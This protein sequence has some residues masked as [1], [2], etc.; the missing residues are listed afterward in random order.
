MERLA[1]FGPDFEKPFLRSFGR[2]VLS[3][4]DVEEELY[5][6][7]ALLIRGE[8]IEIVSAAFHAIQGASAKFSVVDNACKVVVENGEL[9]AEWKRLGKK[10]NK[11]MTDRNALAHFS[12][13][14]KVNEPPQIGRSFFDKRAAP[15]R[16]RPLGIEDF[17]QFTQTFANLVEEMRAF[18]EALQG[19]LLV[20]K[21]KAARARDASPSP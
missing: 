15:K 12:V 11:C 8:D 5:L 6:L 2:A 1:R 18:Y 4:Q 20:R 10:I 14:S 19:P 7:F 3:W 9:A 21:R 17:D 13:S 16:Y